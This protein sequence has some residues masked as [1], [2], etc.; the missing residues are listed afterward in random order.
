LRQDGYDGR[1]YY[2]CRYGD[3]CHCAHTQKEIKIKPHISKWAK[4]SKDKIDLLQIMEKVTTIIKSS[5]DYVINPKYRSMIMNIEKLRF[6]ELLHF[7]FD[8][9]C[10][11]RRI[12]K[13]DKINY[14]KFSRSST[15]VPV[16]GFQFKD[17]IPLF[18]LDPDMEETVWALQ[19]TLRL[20]KKNEETLPNVPISVKELCCGDINC[21]EGV[22]AL[23][24]LVCIDNMID[25]KCKC[26]TFEEN[27]AQKKSYIA[28][29]QALMEII[30][31]I[32]VDKKKKDE[33]VIEYNKIVAKYK[34][35]EVYTKLIH[36]TESGLI[37]L[38][39]RIKDKAVIAPKTV[40]DVLKE[41]KVVKRIVKKQY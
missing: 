12:A 4:D 35:I 23:E 25:G 29:G 22:H 19:R 18:K 5:S 20:C 8:I 7:W 36:M 11:H 34:K 13:S 26:P 41:V 15:P 27:E 24:H 14:K 1:G 33:T 31:N 9:T 39:E 10:Y 30:N 40:D 38:C 32:N 37:P 17:D 3:D 28:Q 2:E 21:K 16:E 6:D